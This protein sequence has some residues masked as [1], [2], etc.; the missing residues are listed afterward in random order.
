MHLGLR[1]SGRIAQQVVVVLTDVSGHLIVP[2][3]L[4]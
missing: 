1:C 4:L 3:T 2:E